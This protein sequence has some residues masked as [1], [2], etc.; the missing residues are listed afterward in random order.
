MKG[1]EL[2]LVVDEIFHNAIVTIT[3][4]IISMVALTWYILSSTSRYNWN[5]SIYWRFGMSI[6]VNSAKHLLWLHLWQVNAMVECVVLLE[7]FL[8]LL[9]WTPLAL[10]IAVTDDSVPSAF[11]RGCLEIG[12]RVNVQLALIVSLHSIQFLWA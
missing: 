2:L 6:V 4:D 10:K 5:Q 11:R 1:W 7:L 8:G 12:V 3:F 9:G